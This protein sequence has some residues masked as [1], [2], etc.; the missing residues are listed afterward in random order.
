MWLI[1]SLE[2]QQKYPF[3]ETET[4]FD[5]DQWIFYVIGMYIDTYGGSISFFFINQANVCI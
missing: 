2:S 4:C 5:S 1:N 3:L